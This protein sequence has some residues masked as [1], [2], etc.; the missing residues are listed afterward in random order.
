[1]RCPG[2]EAGDLDGARR[3][4]MSLAEADLRCLDAHAHLG[5]LELD[6][7]PD[8]AL[9][10]Y[11]VGVRIGEMSLGPSFAGVLSWGYTDN[12][13]FLRC[14]HGLGLAS[15]DLDLVVDF[16]PMSPREHKRAYFGLLAALEALVERPVDLIERGAVLNPFVRDSI[17][18]HQEVLYDAA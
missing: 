16:L 15:S 18:R 11:L 3:L 14:M 10:H 7:R 8:L 17:E 12:R 2:W 5:N 9:R 4:L 6:H 1:V 13:P